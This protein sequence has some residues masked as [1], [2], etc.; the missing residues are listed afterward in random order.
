MCALA[1][2]TNGFTYLLTYVDC[3]TRWMEAILIADITA[4]TIA[5]AFVAGWVA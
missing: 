2:P 3:F 5:S 4:E 1:A